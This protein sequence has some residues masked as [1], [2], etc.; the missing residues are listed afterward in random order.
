MTKHLDISRCPFAVDEGRRRNILPVE[1]FCLAI[2]SL[3]LPLFDCFYKRTR[4]I[5]QYCM[6]GQCS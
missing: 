4:F 6:G 2:S 3:P 5:A 1:I